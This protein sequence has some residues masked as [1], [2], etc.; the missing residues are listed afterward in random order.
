MPVLCEGSAVEWNTVPSVPCAFEVFT[1]TPQAQASCVSAV[2]CSRT[3]CAEAPQAQAPSVSAVSCSCPLAEAPQAQAF[4]FGACVQ[5]SSGRKHSAC[6]QRG[7][8]RGHGKEAMRAEPCV[9]HVALEL[10]G[11][12]DE[13]VS[14]PPV[15]HRV[16]MIRGLPVAAGAGAGEGA[17]D[18]CEACAEES[19]ACRRAVR[20]LA[21]AGE[22]EVEQRPVLEDLKAFVMSEA[23]ETNEPL[24]LSPDLR[25]S[26]VPCAIESSRPRL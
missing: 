24:A 4:S 17:G 21:M 6:V 5:R 18:G 3:V 15:A 12:C 13:I 9:E 16:C 1:Q 2:S 19:L 14:E 23:I 22:I 20:S 10:R 25:Q 7:S 26:P 11:G 8:G